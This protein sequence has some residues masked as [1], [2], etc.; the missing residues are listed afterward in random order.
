MT[1]DA[2]W[3]PER[4]EQTDNTERSADFPVEIAE[5][6]ELVASAALT[7]AT[8]PKSTPTQSPML[9]R[10]TH[11]GWLFTAAVGLDRRLTFNES[12]E[13]PDSEEEAEWERKKM[14]CSFCRMFLES[15]CKNQFKLWSK[16]VDKAKEDGLEF[17]DVCSTVSQNLFQCTSEHHDYFAALNEAMEAER[18]S[19]G[20][21]AAEDSE[22]EEEETVKESGK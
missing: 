12:A 10:S 19:E 20:D 2:S 4:G 9:R 5:S 22:E 1:V 14:E 16:C 15:P 6:A 8:E 11:L 17:K 18:S 3:S 13:T 7:K 21:D